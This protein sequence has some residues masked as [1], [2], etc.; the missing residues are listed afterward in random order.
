YQRQI[1]REPTDPAWR[2]AW[3][4]T[5][6]IVLTMSEE[7]ARR[8]A[9][10]AVVTLTNG[11]QVHPDPS[12][13]ERVRERLGVPDLD[14]PDRRLRELGERGGFGVLTLAPPFRRFAESN[15]VFL[16]GF[17][18]NLGAGHWNEQGHKLAGQLIASWLCER[19]RSI[20][21]SGLGLAP[22]QGPEGLDVRSLGG[23][24]PDRDADHPAPVERGGREVREPR[25]VH[26]VAP[27]QGV[28]VEGVAFQA[29]RLVAD[30]E[31]LQGDGGE[32]RPVG[33]GSDPV[34]QPS[35]VGDVPAKAG[36][37]RLD[38]LGPE[39]APELEGPETPT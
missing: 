7:V 39:Q 38:P 24:G 34:E 35:G 32:D 31:G 28:G 16:H 13:V 11:A 19:A 3:E 26:P 20:H 8:G 17:E 2:S 10:F 23:F 37:E 15:H 33:R 21:G 22:D 12:V 29:G 30:A 27:G 14:Y 6:R 25:A 18:P 5:E 1:Y 36:P 9:T 4:L